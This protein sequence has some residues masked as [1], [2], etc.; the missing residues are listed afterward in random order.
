VDHAVWPYWYTFLNLV[1]TADHILA[2]RVSLFEKLGD[3]HAYWTTHRSGLTKS[4][5]D[6]V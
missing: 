5:L 4:H 6:L 1:L 3:P 2:N